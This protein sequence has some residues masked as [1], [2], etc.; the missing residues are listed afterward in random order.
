MDGSRK[1]GAV[2]LSLIVIGAAGAPALTP[3][4]PGQRFQD[5]ENA[6]PMRPRVIDAAGAFARPFVYPIR[7]VDRLERRYTEDR[8]RP[9]PIR[10]FANGTVVSI[11]ESAGPWLPLGG[12]PLGRDVFA[13]LLYGAR[14]S[15]GVACIG[16]IGALMLGLLIGGTAG[17]FGG[18]LDRLLMSVADFVLVLPAIYVVLSIRAALPLVLSVHEVFLALTLLL[19]LAGWPIAA[20]GVRAIIAAERRK[21]YAEAAH[22]LGAGPW[23]ILLRHLLPSTTAFLLSIWTMM[24]PAFVLTE[25][26]LSFVG[27]GFPIPAATW[28]AMLRDA[29]Q[30]AA[31]L[32]APWL[33]APGAAIVVTVLAL[34]LLTAIPAVDGPQAG[35]FS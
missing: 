29:W 10:W 18:R 30:G 16:S 12:D 20:R 33:M 7:V 27:L 35:T 21:E 6:P 9:M 26:T 31:L 11:E 14:L 2:L 23:R 17:F 19:A 15:L 25:A 8:S 5:Y 28:G 24:V 1:T 13:R 22:A 32:S 4:A 3:H 34:H